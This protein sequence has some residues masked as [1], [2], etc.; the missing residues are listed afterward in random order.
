[1]APVRVVAAVIVDGDKVL[2]CR[3]AAHK[4][5][6]GYWEFPGGKVEPGETDQVA[7]AREIREE[8]R[9]EI[10]VGE[11]VG[12]SIAR[13]GDVEIELVAYFARVVVDEITNSLDHDEFRWLLASELDSLD[14]APADVPI[15]TNVV[16]HV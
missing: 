10:E 7:L 4:S 13:A 16:G 2:A 15:L 1:V 9:V 8:L 14:W 12:N 5:M 11:L 6:A 3:R